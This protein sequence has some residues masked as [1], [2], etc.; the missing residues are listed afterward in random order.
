MVLN[1]LIRPI[2]IIRDAVRQDTLVAIAEAN[3]EAPAA[4]PL[5]HCPH[6]I[7]NVFAL[8]RSFL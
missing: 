7:I 1:W 5:N 3:D 2:E 8:F 6:R 4:V